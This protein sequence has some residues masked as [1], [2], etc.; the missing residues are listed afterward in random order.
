MK[1]NTRFWSFLSQFFLKCEMLQTKLVEKIETLIYVQQLFFEN[2]YVKCG[3]HMVEP[4]RP[5]T[6]KWRMRIAYRLTRSTDTHLLTKY[7]TYC[8]STVTMVTSTRLNVR[9]LSG[10]DYKC[11]ITIKNYMGL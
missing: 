6:T 8:C 3:K 5:Q 9:L 11:K 1:I 4:N 2:R 7:N 10:Y